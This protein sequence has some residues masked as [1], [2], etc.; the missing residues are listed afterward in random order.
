MDEAMRQ[1]D[2]KSPKARRARRLKTWRDAR[3]LSFADMCQCCLI[4]GANDIHVVES[5]DYRNK[6][7]DADCGVL[8]H[9]L[10][11]LEDG[12][13]N[14]VKAY[15]HETIFRFPQTERAFA[16]YVNS[17]PK[18][19]TDGY[20]YID[21]PKYCKEYSRVDGKLENSKKSV[22]SF[23]LEDNYLTRKCAHHLCRI[24]AKLPGKLWKTQ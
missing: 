1:A 16:Y 24:M 13:E 11:H 8:I 10:V 6:K 21:I 2:A 18:D 15:K 23:N 19:G 5:F 14:T 12:I 7:L 9:M 20:H 17:L 3:F 4:S 22:E